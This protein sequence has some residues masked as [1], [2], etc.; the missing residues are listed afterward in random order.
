MTKQELRQ[1]VAKALV[2]ALDGEPMPKREELAKQA[3]PQVGAHHVAE[4]L[5][6]FAERHWV[7]LGSDGD[8]TINGSR[9]DAIRAFADPLEDDVPTG[10]QQK[11]ARGEWIPL[12]SLGGGGQGDIG[13]VKH[14]RHGQLGA[15]KTLRPHLEGHERAVLRFRREIRA[16]KDIGSHPGIVELLDYDEQACWY[17]TRYAPL[18]SLQKHLRRFKGDVL[19]VLRI[20]RDLA[21]TLG[22][23]HAAGVIHRDLKADN[24]LLVSWDHAQLVDFGIAHA[25]DDTRVTTE[26]AAATAWYSPPWARDGLD[27]EPDAS[28]DTY[29]LGKLIY[30]MLAG[31][32]RFTNADGFKEGKNELSTYLGR[33]DLAPVTELLIKLIADEHGQAITSMEDVVA[34]IDVT[35]RAVLTPAEPV[36]MP[37]HPRPPPATGERVIRTLQREEALPILELRIVSRS[38]EAGTMRLKLE[39]RNMTDILALDPV[40]GI[41]EGPTTGSL[42]TIAPRGELTAQLK[43]AGKAPPQEMWIE[44][45]IRRG[46]RIRNH[47]KLVA[48]ERYRFTRHELLERPPLDA[49]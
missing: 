39:V 22:D 17:V 46:H 10:T 6:W 16:F 29:A 28:L 40:I 19:R 5:E 48:D 13:L 21:V 43:H 38:I 23:V 18:G 31:G 1:F 7:A 20:G 9:A 26:R 41:L 47:Y 32:H 8:M 30:T 27:F 44:Y 34:L 15:L 11:P 4:A 2:R 14:G 36:A 3:G 25:A 12:R 33:P 24:V 45:A 42:A 37:R 49:P 35:L